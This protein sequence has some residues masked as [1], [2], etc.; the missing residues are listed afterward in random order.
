MIENICFSAFQI[1][2]WQHRMIWPLG[3]TFPSLPLA[4]KALHRICKC[5]RY[6]YLIYSQKKEFTEISSKKKKRKKIVK[7]AVRKQG[8]YPTAGQNHPHK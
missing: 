3:S 7:H 5:L 2:W 6:T 1:G 4:Y 8:P